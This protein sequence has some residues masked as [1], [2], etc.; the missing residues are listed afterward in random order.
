LK[1]KLWLLERVYIQVIPENAQREDAHGERIAAV[2]AITTEKLSDDLVMVFYAML[3]MRLQ[4][5]YSVLEAEV[6]LVIGKAVACKGSYQIAQQCYF[7]CQ[8]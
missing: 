2:S 5:S 8:L 4:C 6:V 7:T 3:D 1:R